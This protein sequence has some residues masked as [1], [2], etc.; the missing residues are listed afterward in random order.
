MPHIALCHSNRQ[1]PGIPSRKDEVAG[2]LARGELELAYQP[3]YRLATGQL[4]KMEAL[5]RWRRGDPPVPPDQFVPWME[6]LGV[7]HAVGKWV[8]EHACEQASRWNAQGR[9]A[10][11]CFNVSPRQLEA[12]DFPRFV[13]E[14]LERTQCAPAWVELE[15]TEHCFIRDFARTR[16]ALSELS[17]IGLTIA[18][19]DFGRG[20][21]SLGCLADLPVQSIKL[22]R[23][24]VAGVHAEPRRAVIVA[25]VM[26][27]CRALGLEVT[28]E[29][30]EHPAE[31]AFLERFDRIDVQGFLFGRP[32]PAALL[33]GKAWIRE[34]L[35]DEEIQA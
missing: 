30:V 21:S 6:D 2:A 19:D 9:G 24:L 23:A 11:V 22:D 3:I 17:R 12:D 18:L 20:Y 14:C 13:R 31:A 10:K 1:P 7:I 15:I 5:L 34:V 35:F 28:A 27:L 32:A 26:D 8:I 25:G 16:A 29:G 4:T 33:P